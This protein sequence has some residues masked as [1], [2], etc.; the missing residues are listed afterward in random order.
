MVPGA[1]PGTILFGNRI[2]RLRRRGSTGAK[3]L[4]GSPYNPVAA[5][6]GNVLTNAIATGEALHRTQHRAHP[7]GLQS[8]SDSSQAVCTENPVRVY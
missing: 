2:E 8:R 5:A 1:V 6:L 4:S 3:S 7:A